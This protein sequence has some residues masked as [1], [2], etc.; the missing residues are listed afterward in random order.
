MSTIYLENISR[1]FPGGTLALDDVS[2]EIR[3]GEVVTVVGPSG[4]G[5][6]TLLRIIAGLDSPT[7]GTIHIDNEPVNRIPP[8]SRNIAMVFQSYALY[9]HMTCYENLALNLRLH[10]VAAAEIDR[11]VK[12]TSRLLEIESLLGSKPGQLSGGQRQR[13]AVGRALIRNPRAFL[14]DEPLS[15]LDALLRERVRHDLKQLFSKIGATVVYVTHDQLEATTLADRVVVLDKGKIQQIG[16]PEQLYQTPRNRFVA[17][18]I[19]SPS[20]NLLEALLEEG[21]WRAGSTVVV[22][23]VARSGPVWLGIRPEAIRFG[24][25]AEASVSW[26]ENLGARFLLGVQLGN[27][28]LSVLAAERP[29]SDRVSLSIDPAEIHVFDKETG[30]NLLHHGHRGAVPC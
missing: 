13:V 18:F 30:E 3:H 2:L 4:C 9:P 16:T 10:K 8:R 11:R 23:G 17:S 26:V 19:G 6:S 7:S 5:K 21:V 15:N 25:G 29:S 14:F 1:R 27:F 24:P 28:S 20:M 22:T 12:E